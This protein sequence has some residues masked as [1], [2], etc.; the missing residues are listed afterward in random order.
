ME[1]RVQKHLTELLQKSRA[2]TRTLFKDVDPE[3]RVYQN[4]GWRIRDIIGHVAT[5]EREV[6]KSLQAFSRGEEYFITNL[7]EDDFNEQSVQEQ[8]ALSYQDVYEEWEKSREDFIEAIQKVSSD[9]IQDDLLYPWGDERGSV[10]Q[11]VEYMI[12]H[13]EQHRDEIV[14][15]I[16]PS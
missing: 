3:L 7:E 8:M 1:S 11:L 16:K 10:Q 9:L 15:V 14:S 2:I 13:E 6:T 5:W 12:E 4:T